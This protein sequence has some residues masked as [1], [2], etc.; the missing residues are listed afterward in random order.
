MH[1]HTQPHKHTR[2]HT[3]KHTLQIENSQKA[4]ASFFLFVDVAKNGVQPCLVRSSPTACFVFWE[5]F[6]SHLIF[7]AVVVVIHLSGC[8]FWCACVKDDLF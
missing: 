5:L 7:V 3:R 1:A 8:R 4:A 6:F 2:T